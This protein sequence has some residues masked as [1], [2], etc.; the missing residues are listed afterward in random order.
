MLGRAACP[1]VNA[2]FL[3]YTEEPPN[4]D[5]IGDKHF[6][7]YLEVGPFLEVPPKFLHVN[8]VLLINS[9]EVVCHQ[10]N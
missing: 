7:H 10:Q 3:E 6:G 8:Y 2:S 9:G 5:H 4:S 1:W